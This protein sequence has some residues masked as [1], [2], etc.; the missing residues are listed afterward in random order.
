MEGFLGEGGFEELLG[1]DWREE[2]ENAEVTFADENHATVR[3]SARE[4]SPA[5]SSEVPSVTAY[6]YTA[7][8]VREDGEWLMIVEEE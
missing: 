7:E 6:T 4:E 1:E 8:L 5:N 3:F 2:L